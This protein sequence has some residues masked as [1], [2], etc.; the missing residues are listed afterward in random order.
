MH[1]ILQLLNLSPDIVRH[2]RVSP[3]KPSFPTSLRFSS[4][5]Q[6]N[7]FAMRQRGFVLALHNF[8]SLHQSS[9]SAGPLEDGSHTYPSLRTK[10]AMP[11]D[12]AMQNG[13]SGAAETDGGDQVPP[14]FPTM[15]VLIDFWTW[16]YSARHFELKTRRIL[17][18]SP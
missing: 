11:G 1:L 17:L 16:L 6:V 15:P 4:N 8:A 2:G 10:K 12:G 9:P 7:C 13:S 5:G 3:W 14:P 18:R